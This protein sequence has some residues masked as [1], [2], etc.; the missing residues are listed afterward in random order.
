MATKPSTDNVIKGGND[1]L[2][3]DQAS[4]IELFMNSSIRLGS[5]PPRQIVIVS[6]TDA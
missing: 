2:L 6:S 1:A 3:D 4:V 5:L